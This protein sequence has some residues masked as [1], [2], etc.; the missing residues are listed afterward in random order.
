VFEGA[1]R[2]QVDGGPLTVYRAGESWLE[3]PGAAYSVNANASA[4]APARLLAIF[5][6]A[7]GAERTTF[8]Q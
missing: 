3:P 8:D 4:T 6:A 2:S 1:I 5:V 7:S